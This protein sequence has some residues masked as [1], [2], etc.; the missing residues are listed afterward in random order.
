MELLVLSQLNAEPKLV[1]L[2]GEFIIQ[3][4]WISDVVR[5]LCSAVGF[6]A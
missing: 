1:F 5:L 4:L 6:R 3:R 2:P